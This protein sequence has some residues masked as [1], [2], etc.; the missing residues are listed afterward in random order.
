MD[1]KIYWLQEQPVAEGVDDEQE[2]E[3]IR[4]R[5]ANVRG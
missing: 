3:E 1:K 4:A 5:L 2:L